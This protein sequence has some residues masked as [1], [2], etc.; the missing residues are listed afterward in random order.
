[1]SSNV[2]IKTKTQPAT[3]GAV[4]RTVS[5]NYPP[6]GRAHDYADLIHHHNEHAKARQQKQPKPAAEHVPDTSEPDYESEGM[7]P[8]N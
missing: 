7:L 1:M 8:H 2:D 5:E 3:K 4:C 6:H